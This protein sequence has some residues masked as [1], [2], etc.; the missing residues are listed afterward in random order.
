MPSYDQLD[1]EVWWIREYEPPALARFNA[2]LRA[3]YGLTRSQCGSKGDNLHLRGRHRSVN[4]ILNSAYCTNRTYAAS[5]AR[6]RRGPQDAL[7]ATDLGLSGPALWAVCRRVDAAVRAGRLPQLAEWYGTFD[8]RTVVGWSNGKPATSDTSHLT[9]AHFGSW[10][11]ST[12]H[13]AYYELFYNVITGDGDDMDWNESELLKGATLMWDTYNEDTT[14]SPPN[15]TGVKVR[16]EI[17]L[18]RAVKQL[19]AAAAADATRDAVTLAA[20]E[21]L[22]SAGGVDAAP[23][24]AA[25]KAEAEKTRALVEQQHAEEMAALRAEHAAEL[26]AAR[27]VVEARTAPTEG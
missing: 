24:V 6:D 5:D 3:R 11:E 4:W 26:A 16:K 9:H 17:P 22:A 20:I 23:I 25:I 18:T 8:G 1:N 13:A 2:R 7:R 21:A 10:T 27:A 15:G 14:S 19:L 12:D